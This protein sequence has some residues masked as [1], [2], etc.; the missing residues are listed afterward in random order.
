MQRHFFRHHPPGYPA[1][2]P[3]PPRDPHASRAMRH[4]FFARL[5]AL[6]VFFFVFAC[7]GLAAF[8]W[9]IANLISAPNS[10]DSA[11]LFRML[12]FIFL[13]G[14][15][16][17]VGRGL[18][19]VALPIGDLVQAA[20]RVAEGDYDVQIAERGPREV[21]ALAHAFNSMAARLQATDE[22]RRNLL[23]DIT[24]ELR[25]PLTIIQG[26]LEGL[27][28][29][30]YPR[31]DAHLAPI[32][33]ETRVLA[34]VIDDLRMLALAESGALQLQKEPTDLAM[35][36]TETAASFQPQA[37]AAGIALNVEIAR[38]APPL[39]L[40]PARLRQ[41]LENIIANALHFTPRGGT[42]ALKCF[43]EHDRVLI[44][45]RDSGAGIAPEDLPHIFERFYKARDSRGTGLGL[46]IAKSLVTAHGGEIS[47]Q[48]EVGI[49]TTIQIALPRVVA[50]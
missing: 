43:S 35:L 47:A 7:G 24:H 11:F 9:L 23:A 29:G 20:G 49:G 37:D 6:F 31:D 18:S 46:A 21:R 33:D 50:S 32:L 13:F 16:I 36:I 22:Q 34:R 41:V 28:D 45:T 14:G 19:R 2:E 25:T 26:N 1:N 38:A 10:P 44:E 39:D 4:R 8:I 3:F 15:L 5:F 42:I 40:D 30:M 17:L 48:S 12:A 27:L